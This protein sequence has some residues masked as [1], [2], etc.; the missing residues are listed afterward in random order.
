MADN[1][2]GGVTRD[3]GLGVGGL[4]DSGGVIVED[5]TKEIGEGGAVFG[6]VAEKLG[7]AVGPG[8]LFR[9]GIGDEPAVFAE[10]GNY[11][12]GGAGIWL[13]GMPGYVVFGGHGES[14]AHQERPAADGGPYKG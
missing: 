5:G 10:D 11:V 2:A 4:Q 6:V 13:G 1:V 8:D 14:L 9:G 7:G 12:G 3:G